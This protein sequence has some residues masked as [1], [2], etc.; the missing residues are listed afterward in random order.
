MAEVIS[1]SQYFD[2]ACLCEEGIEREERARNPG[3]QNV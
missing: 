1:F 2:P 3:H